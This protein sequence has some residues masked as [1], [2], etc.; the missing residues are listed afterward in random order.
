MR[1]RSKGGTDKLS[2]LMTLCEACHDQH[3]KE[4]L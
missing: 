2:N 3:H 4:G 1:P